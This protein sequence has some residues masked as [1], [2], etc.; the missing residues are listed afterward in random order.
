VALEPRKRKHRWVIIRTARAR[1]QIV[2]VLESSAIVT[3]FVRIRFCKSRADLTTS[4]Q[5]T[6]LIADNSGRFFGKSPDFSREISTVA[7]A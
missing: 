2:H 6:D 5:S 4:L 3:H 1:F 7:R